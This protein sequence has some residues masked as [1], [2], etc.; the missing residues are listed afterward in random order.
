MSKVIF[1]DVRKTIE[2]SLPSFAESKV[3]LYE[4]LLFGQVNELND[5]KLKEIDKG[6]LSLKYLVKEWN[7]TDEKGEALPIEIKTL[8]Q[9]PVADL[10]FLLEKVSDFFTQE[11][12]GEKKPSKT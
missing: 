1:K 2:V 12:K 6:V 5:E 10:T 4:S 3:V 8:N 7:F 11:Q 9:F